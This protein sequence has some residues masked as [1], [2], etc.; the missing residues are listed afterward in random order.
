[1]R[2]RRRLLVRPAAGTRPTELDQHA[3]RRVQ[4][5]VER[6]HARH[7]V[8]QAI[9]VELRVGPEL[10][11]EPLDLRPAHELVGEDHPACAGGAHHREVRHGRG[12]HAPRARVELAPDQLRRQRRLAVRGERQVALGAPLVH[13]AQVVGERALAQHQ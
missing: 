6:R 5:A 4:S 9:H 7:R 8:D 12:G 11:L 1:V 2:P 10:A 13:R 3:Q